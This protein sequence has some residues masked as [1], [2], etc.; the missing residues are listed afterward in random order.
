MFRSE[1]T[2]LDLTLAWLSLV[3]K[4]LF[5]TIKKCS[6]H[7]TAVLKYKSPNVQMFIIKKWLFEYMKAWLKND[8]ERKHF[9]FFLYDI[10]VGL[11]LYRDLFFNEGECVYQ[12]YILDKDTFGNSENCVLMSVS[13]GLFY[14]IGQH[15]LEHI[16]EAK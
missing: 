6:P 3:C 7:C 13:T 1:L 16:F 5:C 4:C 11:F 2:Y 12:Q 8:I 14:V 9:L 15:K 10:L